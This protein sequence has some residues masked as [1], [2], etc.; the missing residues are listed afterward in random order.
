MLKQ[1][2]DRIKMA[3]G[4]NKHPGCQIVVTPE[5]AEFMN[6]PLNEPN[7]N[8]LPVVDTAYPAGVQTRDDLIGFIEDQ[9]K[10]KLVYSGPG[11]KAMGKEPDLIDPTNR[12]CLQKE[13]LDW[14]SVSY[15]ISMK[16][17]WEVGSKSLIDQE[18]AH[19]KMRENV[20]ILK[21]DPANPLLVRIK[22]HDPLDPND[23]WFDK[24]EG[25]E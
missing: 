7:S 5:V 24:E 4:L 6:K 3:L 20:E 16:Q 13:W 17:A 18:F 14:C 1:L 11:L 19:G 15:S 10:P 2:Y 9:L 8:A 21:W 22:Y 12:R 23:D 25:N